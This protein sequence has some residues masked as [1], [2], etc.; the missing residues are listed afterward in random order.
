[1]EDAR[2]ILKVELGEVNALLQET[3]S[4]EG[5]ERQ[6]GRMCQAIIAAGGKRLRPRLAL[7]CA[8]AL[9]HF[10]PQRHDD[11]IR[12]AAACELLHSA[13]LIHDDVID[14]ATLRRGVP[15]LN[16]TS[17]NHAAVLA[18]DYMFTRMFETVKGMDTPGLIQALS[19]T[20]STL[21]AGEI[22]QLQREGD[23]SLTEEDYLGT[24]YAKTGALFELSCTCVAISINEDDRLISALGAFGRHLGIAFQIIDDLLDY[25]SSERSL[26]KPVGEDLADARIT[27]PLILAR[28]ALGAQDLPRLDEA[29]RNADL[30]A[31]LR[32]IHHTGAP[33]QCRAR[34]Q[35]AVEKAKEAL[36]ALPSSVWVQEL[37]RLADD[38]LLRQS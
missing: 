3:F 22:E 18:G 33:G 9:P 8:H 4:G 15:T 26:G 11:L 32:F 27:L 29:V 20:L 17:G 1:M 10:D 38:S 30:Q 13:T 35:E 2:Q 36:S 28:K 23:L 12:A 6:V 37:A 5:L 31:T 34:A 19:G 14:H 25:E 24:V 21:V 7:L 16:D